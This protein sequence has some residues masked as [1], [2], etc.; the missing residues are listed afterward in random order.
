M[1]FQNVAEWTLQSGGGGVTATALSLD[2]IELWSG[3]KI[4]PVFGNNN[5][6]TIAKAFKEGENPDSWKIGD[7]KS[8]TLTDGVTYTIRLCDMQAGRYAYA[9]GSGSSKAVFEFVELVKVGSTST[10]QIN[11]SNTNVGG[12]ANCYMRETN[13]PKIEA[14]LP[15]DMLA[16]ISKVDVLSGTGGGTG[17]GTSSSANKLFIPAEMEMF[18]SQRYSIGISECPLGQFDYYKA[19]NTD[20]DRV[21]INVGTTTAYDYWLRS[22]GSYHATAFAK[23]YMDGSVYNANSSKALGVSPI[24]AI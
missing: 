22:P 7:T 14:L 21:K 10:F 6:K 12:W 19:H 4:D 18:S 16:A 8:V 2:D 15:N 9:D 1:D 13:I 17:S 23:V 24:F 3:F 11:T 20:S 5:W